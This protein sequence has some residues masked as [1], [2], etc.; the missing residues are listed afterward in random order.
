MH[1]IYRVLQPADGIVK[2]YLFWHFLLKAIEEQPVVIN[3]FVE[4]SVACQSCTLLELG[5]NYTINLQLYCPFSSFFFRVVSD[6]PFIFYV[7]GCSGK[8]EL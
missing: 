5:Q 6:L 7:Q 4:S 1:Q 2:S 8:R 3:L